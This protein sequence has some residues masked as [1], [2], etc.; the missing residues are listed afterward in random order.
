MSTSSSLFSR[1]VRLLLVFVLGWPDK[2]QAQDSCRVSPTRLEYDFRI[3][4]YGAYCILVALQLSPKKQVVKGPRPRHIMLSSQVLRV[5]SEVWHSQ[6]DREKFRDF[7]PL[8]E[9]GKH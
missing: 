3:V 8:V 2:H 1:K 5:R 7:S 4:T 9:S 6:Q